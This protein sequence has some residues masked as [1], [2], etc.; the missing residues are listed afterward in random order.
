[1]AAQLELDVLQFYVDGSSIAS[2][3]PVHSHTHA[4]GRPA[5]FSSESF[6][7]RR[8]LSLRL[9]NA[10]EELFGR[11]SRGSGIESREYGRRD[12]SR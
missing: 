5:I 3:L 9:V 4:N 6:A 2:V 1:M 7:Y 8:N 11:N 12:T 10:I